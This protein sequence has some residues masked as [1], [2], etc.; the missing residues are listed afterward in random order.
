MNKSEEELLD[1]F[2]AAIPGGGDVLLF[3]SPIFW[4][5]S[6]LLSLH[7][8]Q[9][10]CRRAG[11]TTHVFYPN[12]LYLII[13]GVD[14]HL[15]IA[16]ENYLF[17]GERLFSAA[18]FGRSAVVAYIEKFLNSCWLP[19]H[20]WK[21][22]PHMAKQVLDVLAPFRKWIGSAD[23]EQMENLTSRWVKAISQRIAN[24]EYRV[25]GCSTSPGGLVPAIAL[26]DGIK[27][28]NADVITVL[29]GALCEGVMAEGVFSLK[30]GIDYVFS[31]EGEITF[32]DFV[33]Q[34]LSGRLPEQKIIYGE[35]VADLDTIPIPDYREY[36]DQLE[37][38]PPSFCPSPDIIEVPYETSRGCWYGKC[39]FCGYY[40][41]KNLYREKSLDKVIEALKV[42]I[43]RHGNYT[44]F[45]TDNMM[46]YRYI[47]TL[48]PRILKEIS[49][50]GFRYEMKANLTLKQVLSIKNA[51]AFSIDAG[52]ESLSPSLLRRM[53]KG[54]EVRENI[55][56]LRYARSVTLELCWFLLFGIPG[57]E[58]EEYEEMLHLLPLIHHLPP[59]YHI[60]PMMIFRFSP[61]QRFPKKFGISNL[62]PADVYKD[63]LP[64]HA[65]LG[66]MAYY[67]TG[68]FGTQA[69]KNPGTIVALA[70][71][72][73]AWKRAWAAY[74][75]VPLKMMLPTL[76]ITRK[77][78]DDY[79]LQD[80]RGLPGRPERMVLDREQASILLVA[81]PQNSA[82]DFQWAVDA[83]LGVLMDSWYIPLATAEPELLLEFEREYGHNREKEKKICT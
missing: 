16:R 61:Y 18:A 63:I 75:N 5:K 25:M 66:K 41:K 14:L 40:G 24:L 74:K 2:F 80:T 8:L 65:D 36:F 46:P 71:E 55:A 38:L 62:R 39:P 67:F 53:W 22:N 48:L 52:I 1:I 19:D 31:G 79:I 7:L 81:R 76:H 59:P 12:L 58:I 11:I 13:T 68:D 43:T 29:G 57:E 83:K 69:Q 50:I 73:Q 4:G 78:E 6:P 26:L 28:L 37:K 30:T 45:M 72:F 20:I 82:V 15:R 10:A 27:K 49:P 60:L 34:V 17:V 9:G 47:D 64:S 3:P 23:W 44:I 32:P 42:L 21:I 51:G 77:D 56:L 70:K 35:P 33:K 54:V